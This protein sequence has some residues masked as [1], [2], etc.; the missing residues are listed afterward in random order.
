MDV[1]HGSDGGGPVKFSVLS[2]CFLSG[3]QELILLTGVRVTI[4]GV[5][6]ETLTVTSG[7]S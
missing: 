6:G 2:I 3:F 1:S 7:N 4:T 5:I